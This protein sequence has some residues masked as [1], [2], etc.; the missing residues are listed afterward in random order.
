MKI[1]FDLLQIS[2]AKFAVICELMLL[3]WL[4]CVVVVVV[5]DDDDFNTHNNVLAKCYLI[6][7]II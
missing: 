6:K 3:L 5:V 7:Q 2:L 4:L 1:W